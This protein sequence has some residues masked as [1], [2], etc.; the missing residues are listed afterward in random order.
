MVWKRLCLLSGA[1]SFPFYMLIGIIVSIRIVTMILFVASVSIFVFNKSIIIF[2][3]RK[4]ITANSY[5]NIK[6]LKIK[7]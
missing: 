7:N 3:K 6:K 5:F 1:W 4:F 2:N